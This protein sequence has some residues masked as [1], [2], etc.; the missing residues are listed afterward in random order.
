MLLPIKHRSGLPV[1]DPTAGGVFQ[2]CAGGGSPAIL[3]SVRRS[4]VGAREFRRPGLGALLPAP[5]LKSIIVA[6]SSDA[7][8]AISGADRSWTEVSYQRN[9]RIS[10]SLPISCVHPGVHRLDRSGDFNF[11]LPRTSFLSHIRSRCFRLADCRDPVHCIICRRAGHIGKLCPQNPRLR[12]RTGS[13][14]NRLSPARPP[15]PLHAR[16]HFPP[17]PAPAMSSLAPAML[18]HIDPARRPRESRSVTIPSPAVDQAVFFLCSH[19]VTLS[20]ADGVNATSPMAVGRALEVQLSVP[21]H[22]LR[23]TAH[24]PEHYFV[25]FTQP[26]HQVNAVRHGS[27]RVDGTAFNIA[28]W[29]EHDHASFDSLL[30]HVRVVIEKVPM[31]FCSVEGAKEIVGKRVRVDRLDSRTLERGHTN[32]FACWVWTNDVANIPTRDTLGVL[33][34]GAG[35]VEEM[36]GFSPPDR[37]VA[38]PPAT[39]D[40]DMRIHVDRVEDRTP[41]SPRSSHSSQSG[42]PSSGSDDDDKPF[43][44]VAPTSWTMGVE[45][46]QQADRD[47]RLAR[48]PVANL[49]CHGM[50][51]GGHG[52]DQD[53]EGGPRGGGQR[54]WKDVLLRRG[55]APALPLLTP[56][57]RQR[58]RSPPARCRSKETAG[59][60]QGD[61]RTPVAARHPPQHRRS[62]PLPPPLARRAPSEVDGDDS[63]GKDPVDDFFKTAKKPSIVSVIVDG[64]AADVEAATEAVVAA[65]LEFDEAPLLKTTGEA[66]QLDAF[67]PTLCAAATDFRQF[68]RATPSTART[69]EVQL[70]AVTSRVCQL[71]IVGADD[72]LEPRNLFCA[73]TLPLVNSPPAR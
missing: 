14:R 4:G 65:P 67:S 21:V 27:I 72:R 66:V 30:L 18:H 48:A 10:V 41:P 57:P 69:L 22:S 45:D 25:I 60:R 5:R 23:V 34:R 37:R 32:T 13:A 36:E 2:V 59:H 3:R 56:A 54:S 35:R 20:V 58:S 46:G 68:S 17:P 53:G 40:Y 19:V 39:A 73:N 44:M 70:G 42:I 47:Q 64:L 15:H 1:T 50:P 6:P 62:R 31:Q 61:R 11:E 71:E 26:A 29:H 38:P 24:H 12:G 55:R 43:P 28:S 7:Q 63:N 52:R 16:L 8:F 51:R 49:G 33:P 9:R